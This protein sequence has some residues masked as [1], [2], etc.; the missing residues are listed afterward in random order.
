MLLDTLRPQ[1]R[2]A[3]TD[4]LWA[5]GDSIDQVTRHTPASESLSCFK[6]RDC[7]DLGEIS[8]FLKILFLDGSLGLIVAGGGILRVIRR[9]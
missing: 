3:T 1:R 5:T 9:Y 6:V 2:K 7:S 4:D 8:P